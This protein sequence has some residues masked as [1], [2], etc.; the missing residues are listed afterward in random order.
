LHYYSLINL[1]L[2]EVGPTNSIEY[3]YGFASMIISSLYFTLLFGQL[4][5]LYMNLTAEA[6]IRQQEIDTANGV[7][8][9]IELSED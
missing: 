5:I 7:M 2:G 6:T 9:A 4:A 1:G 8:D 3:G